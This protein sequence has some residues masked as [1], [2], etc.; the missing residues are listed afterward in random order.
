MD[1]AKVSPNIMPDATLDEMAAEIEAVAVKSGVPGMSG[2][3]HKAVISEL[4]KQI[5]DRAKAR[6]ETG[7][8]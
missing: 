1:E 5:K 3:E 4:T 2:E 6:G 7:D 8:V